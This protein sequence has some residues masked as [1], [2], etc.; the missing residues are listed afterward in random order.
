MTIIPLKKYPPFNAIFEKREFFFYSR[1][2]KSILQ[3][4]MLAVSVIYN[5]MCVCET[6][7]WNVEYV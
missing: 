7:H 6:G 1:D 5:S 2:Y 3:T 4:L